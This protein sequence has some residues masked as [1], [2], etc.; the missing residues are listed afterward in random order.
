MGLG[1]TLSM[2][3]LIASD[4]DIGNI[5]KR[6]N[7]LQ[8]QR[9]FANSTLIVVPPTVLH[10]WEAELKQHILPGRITWAKHHLKDRFDAAAAANS[11]DVVFTTYQTVMNEHRKCS[12]NQISLFSFHWHR[13]ILDEAH[14]IRN[15]TTATAKAIAS[16]HATYRWAIS[17]TPIQNNLADFASLATFLR[18]HPY[19][20]PRAFDED[21]IEP[22]RAKCIDIFVERMTKLLACVMLRRSKGTIEL[23]EKRAV[24]IPVEFSVEEKAHYRSYEK[25]IVAMLDNTVDTGAGTGTHWF[26]AMQQIT[27]LRMACNLGASATSLQSSR[28]RNLSDSQTI[29]SEIFANSLVTGD[30]PCAQCGR[31]T[32]LSRSTPMPDGC[33]DVYYSACRCIFCNN[34]ARFLS[35]RT[36]DPCAC[37]TIS[38]FPQALSPFPNQDTVM[39]T[40]AD[41]SFISDSQDRMYISSKV[42]A[43]VSEVVA[44]LPE[45][46]VV[47]SFWRSSL[48]VVQQA[49]E[50]ETIQCVRIDGR[51]SESDRQ[52]ALLQFRNDSHTKVMLLTI[53][54]GAVGIDLTAAPRV[55]LLEPQWNP[56]LEDQAL[57]R[58]HRIGQTHPVTT[59]RYF[60]K[61]SIEEYIMSVQGDKREMV[62]LLL[63][64]DDQSLQ[65]LR[66]ILNHDLLCS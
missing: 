29:V 53:S 50:T 24:T 18:F 39:R 3:A 35:F 6:F 21:F 38:P 58:V 10:V 9:Q 64:K 41:M 28:P 66:S 61:D 56:S 26:N 48:D 42:K 33:S 5:S 36:P 27:V 30:P 49:L 37:G 11:P 25:P 46:S 51:V 22:Y 16:L 57:A 12:L 4:K 60:M 62:K 13:I 45:K 65:Q 63:S 32:E 8:T 43:L 1:K 2:I 52:H 23:P 59:Y 19:D 40:S 7:K 54:C 14:I 55:H 17:G 44:G 47:F 20:S 15:R 31:V 34:C